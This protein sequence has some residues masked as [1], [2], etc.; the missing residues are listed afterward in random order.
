MVDAV[1][2]TRM[3][4]STRRGHLGRK[5]AGR[6]APSRGSEPAA[7]TPNERSK[8]MTNRSN[9]STGSRKSG[10]QSGQSQM[11]GG[12]SSQDNEMQSCPTPGEPSR[13][14]SISSDD[15]EEE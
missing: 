1:R 7:A 13:E 8:E 10:S 5:V 9:K 4:G 11:T 15:E 2:A 3:H 12:R 6:D 14:S